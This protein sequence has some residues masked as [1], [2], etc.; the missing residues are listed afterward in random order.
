TCNEALSLPR[1]WDQ[2]WSLRLQQIL[3]YE[4]D[5]LEYPDLFAGSPVV[6][7]KVAALKDAARAEIARIEQ[8]GG[9][10]AAVE[11]GYMKAGL[12]RSQAERLARI[13]KGEMVVVGRNRWTDG[14]PSP[15]LAGEDGG[16]FKF[17]PVS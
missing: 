17:D 16:L 14:L 9:A 5:L 13:N 11:S 6:A 10:L 8:A 12:V 7:A 4:T 15:L 2:Q 3:A 1:P